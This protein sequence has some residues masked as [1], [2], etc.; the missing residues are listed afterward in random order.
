MN[1]LE[2][3][4]ERIHLVGRRLISKDFKSL[5]FDARTVEVSQTF[6]EYKL[7]SIHMA[8]IIKIL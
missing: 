1:F 4:H 8:K 6:F 7:Y 3:T 2:Q 5:S